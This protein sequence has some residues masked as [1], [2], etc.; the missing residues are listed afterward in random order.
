VSQ[1]DLEK[2]F[3]LETRIAEKLNTLH[4]TVNHIRYLRVQLNALNRRIGEAIRCGR[5]IRRPMRC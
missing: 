3:T 5:C 2:Q 4:L 1:A